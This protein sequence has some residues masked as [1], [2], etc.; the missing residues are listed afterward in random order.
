MCVWGI[1]EQ[2]M[3]F[4]DDLFTEAFDRNSFRIGAVVILVR[5]VYMR[6]NEN[7]VVNL[8]EYT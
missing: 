7:L 4:R 2:K 1:K 3:K 6:G 8:Y 5:L